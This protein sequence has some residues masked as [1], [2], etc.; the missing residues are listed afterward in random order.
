MTLLLLLACGELVPNVTMSGTIVDAPD[1]AAAPLPGGTIVTRDGTG[2]QQGEATADDQG[3]FSVA[4]PGG[5]FFTAELAA[6]GTVPT[7]LSGV[8]A[9]GDFE[10]GD[11]HLWSMAQADYDAL[12]TDFSTC[13]DIGE[14]GG[15]VTGQVQ[16]YT[17]G[18]DD[19]LVV[20]TARVWLI[21]EDGT[22]EQ[23]C[24]LDDDGVSDPDAQRTGATGRFAFFG[25]SGTAWVHLQY[26]D[27]AGWSEGWSWQVW[28]PDAG[29]APLYP[30]WVTLD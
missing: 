19:Q 18:S 6:D 12:A 10:A 24:Y 3:D 7:T 30:A 17:D 5:A 27:A 25:E 29:V 1:E 28:V 20:N 22:R 26:Q 4:V 8:A 14:A 23:A 21:R 16:L 2:A 15:V 13:Q 9:S 11:G